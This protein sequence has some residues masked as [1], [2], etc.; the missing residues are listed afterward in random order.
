MLHR[1]ELS[2]ERWRRIAPLLPPERGRPGRPAKDNRC[3]VNAML[4]ILKTGAP[5][6]DLPARYGPWQSVH[7]RFTRWTKQGLWPKILAALNP[8]PDGETY[9]EIGRA[10]V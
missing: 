1:H 2:D 10:H 7:T 6:R 4:W 5:W 8:E 9:S 3:M